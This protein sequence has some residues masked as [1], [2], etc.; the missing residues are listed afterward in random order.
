[1]E[2]SVK[3]IS[4]LWYCFVLS[5]HSG[6]IGWHNQNWYFYFFVPFHL[7]IK[8][9]PKWILNFVQ[10]IS[11]KMYLK[12]ASLQLSAIHWSILVVKSH[13]FKH[14]ECIAQCDAVIWNL[15]W[16]LL[17]DPIEKQTKALPSHLVGT[18]LNWPLNITW[19]SDKLL[20]YTYSFT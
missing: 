14:K 8:R 11:L 17:Y 4:N 5:V 18:W 6:Q 16:Y 3:F 7:C 13:Y 20:L 9:I 2:N 1:M 15:F 12:F 10:F 19:I